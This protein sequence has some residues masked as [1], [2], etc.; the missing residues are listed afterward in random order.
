MRVGNDFLGDFDVFSKFILRSVDHNG[1]K[2]V[3]DAALAKV[4]TIAVVEV[5][6]DRKTRIFFCGKNEVFEVF[7]V[8]ILS[9]AR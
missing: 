4:E 5:K 7:G 8:G 6:N 1:R 9:C 2:A 3:I